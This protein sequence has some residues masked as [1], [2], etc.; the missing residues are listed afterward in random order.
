MA[1]FSPTEPPDTRL[2]ILTD[3]PVS[4]ETFI[5]DTMVPSR[6]ERTAARSVWADAELRHTACTQ[7]TLHPA[8]S[9]ILRRIERSLAAIPRIAITIVPTLFASRDDALTV[10]TARLTVFVGTG[11]MTLPTVGRRTRKL[12]LAARFEG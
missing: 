2:F 10:V 11:T 3:R 6:T 1:P 12:G 5:T 9:T 7:A 4:A 8:Q